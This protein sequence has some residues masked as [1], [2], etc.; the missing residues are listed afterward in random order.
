[1]VEGYKLFRRNRQGRRGGGAALYVKKWMDCRELS[2][3][4]TVMIRL[5]VCG[6]KLGTRP[7]SGGHLI[8]GAVKVLRDLEHISFEG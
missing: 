6:L 7:I 3:K 8:K 5:R 1:M 4:K 2:L